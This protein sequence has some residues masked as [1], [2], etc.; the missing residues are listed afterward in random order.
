MDTHT[1]THTHTHTIYSNYLNADKNQGRCLKI[2]LK[3]FIRLIFK[4]KAREVSGDRQ[5][6]ALQEHS[7]WQQRHLGS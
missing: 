2:K 7:K 5:T 4:V 3:I 6:V 1:H